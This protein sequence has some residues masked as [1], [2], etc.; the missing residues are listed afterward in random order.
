M[1]AGKLDGECRDQTALGVSCATVRS[2]I[3]T[4]WEMGSQRILLSKD[5]KDNLGLGFDH[6]KL[7]LLTQSTAASQT[8]DLNEEAKK[9]HFIPDLPFLS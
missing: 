2:L 8:A 7:Y 3:M 4:L 1:E 5:P 6:S 9:P